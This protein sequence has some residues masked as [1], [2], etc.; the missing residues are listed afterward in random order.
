MVQ[1]EGDV[2]LREEGSGGITCLGV[3]L[4]PLRVGERH[5]ERA[6]RAGF[7]ARV[8]KSLPPDLDVIRVGAD[9]Q[10]RQR[11]L[12][13]HLEMQGKHDRDQRSPGRDAGETLRAG[14]AS[15][16]AP[17]LGA[18]SPERSGSQIIHGQSARW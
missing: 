14:T 2:G 12:R 5:I 6:D 9:R 15:E 13:W 1:I 7:S 3:A 11:S 18:G 4:L 10:H 17:K 16:G 8:S